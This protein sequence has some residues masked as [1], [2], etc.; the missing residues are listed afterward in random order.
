M[1]TP[2][3]THR[4]RVTIDDGTDA[5]YFEVEE[6]P[7]KDTA[8]IIAR[9]LE[10]AVGFAAGSLTIKARTKRFHEPPAI[11]TPPKSAAAKK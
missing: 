3:N 8:N 11:N 6:A 10:K 1:K 5:Y 4:T 2:T 7:A 9:S